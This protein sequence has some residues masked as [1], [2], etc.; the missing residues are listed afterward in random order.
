[1][2]ECLVDANKTHVSK[3]SKVFHKSFKN[4]TMNSVLI[5]ENF[6]K[7]LKL[8]TKLDSTVVSIRSRKLRGKSTL[9]ELEIE[10]LHIPRDNMTT[11]ESSTKE[12]FR[13][14]KLHSDSSGFRSPLKQINN[15]LVSSNTNTSGTDKKSRSN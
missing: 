1:M 14:I 3:V 4:I 11:V 6:D 9:E 12:V 10:A 8:D 5:V 2:V 15:Q 13:K 7:Q